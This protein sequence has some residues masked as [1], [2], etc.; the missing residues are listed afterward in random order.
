[1][2]R[3]WSPGANVGA[4]RANEFPCRRT[5]MDKMARDHSMSRTDPNGAERLTGIYGSD[6]RTVP[7]RRVVPA[8]CLSG[9]THGDSR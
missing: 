9:V 7:R 2:V 6:D 8:A 5:G 3:R 4:T 1:M